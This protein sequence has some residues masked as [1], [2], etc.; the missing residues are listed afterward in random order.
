[1]VTIGLFDK[2]TLKEN[3]VPGQIAMT[4]TDPSLPCDD[5]N[6]VV[7]AAKLIRE[8]PSDSVFIHLEKQIPHGGG[9][10]GGS[11]DAAFTLQAL[12]EFWNLKKSTNELAGLAARLGSDVPFFLHGPS[13]ICRGRGELVQPV[14]SSTIARWALLILPGLSMPT[15]AV[16]QQFDAM[17]YGRQAD[18]EIEPDWNRLA[19]LPSRELLNELVNDLEAPAFAVAPQLGALRASIEQELGRPVRMSG[20]GS[21]LFTLY[22]D[23]AEATA[24]AR[25]VSQEQMAPATAIALAPSEKACHGCKA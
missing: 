19:Q 18:V 1:M 12:D 14:A 13:S 3:P 7:R 11:S 5:R 22:D 23:R 20:S 10:G 17:G 9:L 21:S 25:L 24:A 16:Y 6:L 4:C 15:P 8:I 2:I